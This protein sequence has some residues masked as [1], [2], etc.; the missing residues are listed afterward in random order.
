VGQR[1]N[2]KAAV[3]Y[4]KGRSTPGS[5]RKVLNCPKGRTLGYRIVPDSSEKR[6]NIRP[7]A[8]RKQKK[9]A[10]WSPG[11]NPK[12]RGKLYKLVNKTYTQE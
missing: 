11:E 12:F 5:K 8:L 2:S 9:D 3:Y 4:T 10:E 1:V 6:M 7:Y